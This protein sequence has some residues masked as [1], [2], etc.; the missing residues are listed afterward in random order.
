MEEPIAEFCLAAMLSSVTGVQSASDA[1]RAR[2]ASAAASGADAGFAP[3]FFAPEGAAPYRGEFGQQTV[4]IIGYG[5]IGATIAQRCAAFGCRVVATVGRSTPPKRPP[6]PLAWLGGSGSLDALL[7]EADFIVIA[8]PLTTATR[9]LIGERELGLCKPTAYL[10]NIA[11]GAVC[12]EAALFGALSRAGTA[13]GIRGAAI[14]LWWEW[15]DIGKGQ[16]ECAP[17]DLE[18]HPFHTLP[19]VLFSPHT[20]GWSSTQIERR[21]GHVATNLDALNGTGKLANVLYT[22]EARTTKPLE[23]ADSRD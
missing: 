21:M 17:Y 14:V 3:P 7:A 4:G 19:N 5:K 18:R 6:S 20:S 9:G 16:R 10:V 23:R 13:S 8:C 11:R 2:C 15:P 1:M 22:G 12:D